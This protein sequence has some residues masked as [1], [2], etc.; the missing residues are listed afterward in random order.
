M[1]EAVSLALHLLGQRP[2]HRI[3]VSFRQLTLRAGRKDFTKPEMREIA[4]RLS[5]G[6]QIL[7][8][9]QRRRLTEQ[10]IDLLE[11]L[12][13]GLGHE[14]QLIEPAEHG[15]AAVEAE[16][17]ADARHGGLHVAEEVGDEPG[18]EEE[19]HVRGLHAVAAQV[20][21][22]DL[23]GQHPG[24]A[25]VGAE[26]SF[27]QDEPREVEA[28]HGAEVAHVDFVADADEDQAEEEAG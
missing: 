11:R 13:L 20:G 22:V 10:D 4:R 25:G 2:N 5:D 21:R 3:P 8:H 18:A 15:D 17:E 14:E 19:G 23:G 7:P 27:V 16:R 26:K 24:E 12:I 1:Y 28:G 6:P 9:E